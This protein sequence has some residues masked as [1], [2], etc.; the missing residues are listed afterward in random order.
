M[1]LVVRQQEVDLLLRHE[2]LHR[3]Q[4]EALAIPVNLYAFRARRATRFSH[5]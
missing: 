3:P 1:P 2:H 4:P 5:L